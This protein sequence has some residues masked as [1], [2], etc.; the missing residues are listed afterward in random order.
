MQQRSAV[1]TSAQCTT[2]E[3]WEMKDQFDEDFED[4]CYM[5]RSA[6]DASCMQAC[7]AEQMSARRDE[8]LCAK[9]R[10]KQFSDAV[11]ALEGKATRRVTRSVTR[12][13]Q[14]VHTAM[15]EL[16]SELSYF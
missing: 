14:R 2:S 6:W 13:M 4:A 10:L 9:Q 11:N 12:D 16:L 5:V 8:L 3:F 1:M 7:G 15:Q